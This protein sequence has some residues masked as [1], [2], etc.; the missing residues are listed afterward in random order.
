MA[1]EQHRVVIGVD[2]VGDA[3]VNRYLAA[4][5]KMGAVT[6]QQVSRIR[7]LTSSSDP[8]GG[9]LA[10]ILAVDAKGLRD[11]ELRATKAVAST[12]ALNREVR[13]LQQ[14]LASLQASMR[15]SV[16]FDPAALRQQLF[17]LLQMNNVM[18]SIQDT[19]SRTFAQSRLVSGSGPVPNYQ[20]SA[21]PGAYVPPARALTAGPQLDFERAQAEETRVVRASSRSRQRLVEAMNREA[22]ES[23]RRVG[24]SRSTVASNGVDDLLQI[25]AR[26]QAFADIFRVSGQAALPGRGPQPRT[27]DFGIP[28]PSRF[29]SRDRALELAQDQFIRGLRE[30]IEA[31]RQAA[32][33]SLQTAAASRRQYAFLTRL[34][35]LE[36]QR[37]ATLDLNAAGAVTARFDQGPTFDRALSDLA[38]V[39]AQI[40]AVSLPEFSRQQVN[41]EAA[42]VNRQVLESLAGQYQGRV[43]GSGLQ[44]VEDKSYLV[45]AELEALSRI[46]PTLN[47]AAS[48]LLYT[49]QAT[50]ALL[51]TLSPETR[52]VLTGGAVGAQDSLSPSRTWIRSNVGPD[53]PGMI[54]QDRAYQNLVDQSVAGERLQRLAEEEAR[55]RRELSA[56]SRQ[57]PQATVA[58]QLTQVRE[59]IA[60][61]QALTTVL[62]QRLAAEQNAAFGASYPGLGRGPRVLSSYGEPTAGPQGTKY[63]MI[64]GEAWASHQ[65]Y[66]MIGNL[67]WN[68]NDYESRGYHPGEIEMVEISSQFRR[69]GIATE[70]LTRALAAGYN[71]VHSAERT[72][73]GSAWAMA[74]SGGTAPPVVHPIESPDVW[75]GPLDY[76]NESQLRWARDPSRALVPHSQFYG[77][78]GFGADQ[79]PYLTQAMRATPGTAGPFANYDQLT[80]AI[81]RRVAAEQEA[82]R[83]AE[84]VAQADRR[85][86]EEVGR[87][88][89]TAGPGGSAGAGA[90]AGGSGGG[91]TPPPPPPPPPPGG[92]DFFD[93]GD[94][95]DRLRREFESQQAST[96]SRLESAKAAVASAEATQAQLRQRLQIPYGEKGGFKTEDDAI[97]AVA[98]NVRSLNASYE[99]LKKAA[100]AH[101]KAEQ[102][103]AG[104]TTQAAQATTRAAGGG[105]GGMG[106]GPPGTFWGDFGYGFHGR[107]DK[108]YA[109]QLGQTFKFSV[110]YG[111]AYK[112]LFGLTQT[113]AA[114][115]QEGI[116]F[117]QGMT[118]LAIATGRPK[119]EL[120]TIAADLGRSAVRAG[121][122]PSQGVEIGARSLGLYGVTDASRA[123]QDR[124]MLNSARVVN[125]LAVGAKKSP[126]ELQGDIAAIAQALG[127]GASGQFRIADLDAYMTR[128]FG[129]QQGST[130]ETVAQSASVGKA[131]G[132]T[133]EQ[134]FAIAADMISRTG[135]T[136]SAVAGFMAQI[137]S[138]GGEGS[139]VDVATK[140]GID[141][142]QQLSSIIQ[143]LALLYGN[144]APR[145]Q[146]QISAAFGRGKIQNA[147][148]A[149]LGDYNEVLGRS[150]EAAG[151][152][153]AGQADR[154]FNLRMDNIGGQIAQLSGVMKEFASL[155]GQ[156]GLLDILG[157]GIITFREFLEVVNGL[158]RLWNQMPDSIQRVLIGLAL[159]A[160]ASQSTAVRTAVG[161]AF[162]SLALRGGTPYAGA[163]FGQGGLMAAAGG[164]ASFGAAARS[165]GGALVRMVGPVGLAIGGLL[166]IGALKNSSDRMVAAQE[167]AVVALGGGPTRG[168]SSSEFSAY[169]SEL[170]SLAKQNKEAPGW[171]MTLVTLGRGNNTSDATAARLQTEADRIQGI[172]ERLSAT[173]SRTPADSSVFKS[174]GADDLATGLDSL[175]KSGQTASERLS[176]LRDVLLGTAQA[177]SAA[178]GVFSRKSF[179]QEAAASLVGSAQN[180]FT[181]MEL[182]LGDLDPRS[183]L[184]QLPGADAKRGVADAAMLQRGV[185]EALT[186]TDAQKRLQ[187]GLKDYGV[188]SEADLDPQTADSIAAI[189]G[190][191]VAE[192]VLKPYGANSKVIDSIQKQINAAIAADLLNMAKGVQQT[193]QGS[194]RLSAADATAL[195]GNVVSLS[196]GVMGR[197]ANID[198]RGQVGELRQ[199]IKLL[200]RIQGRTSEPIGAIS[201]AID[202]ARKAIAQAQFNE[203]ERLRRIAQ[204]NADS[205]KEIASI[206]RRFLTREIRAAVRGNDADLLAQILEQAGKGAITI[207]RN[208]I[209]DALDVVNAARRVA[210][211]LTDFGNEVNGVVQGQAAAFRQI[212]AATGNKKLTKRAKEL[213]KLAD[214]PKY[215]LPARGDADVYGSGSDSGNPLL[216]PKSKDAAS[217]KEKDSPAA[218]AAARAQ[219]YATRSESQIAAARA[220]V[221]SAKASLADAKKNTVEYWNAMGELFSAQ[222]ALTDAL[223]AYQKN[224]M[225]L[226][227]DMTNPL[228]MARIETRAA[229]IK[230]R[231]DIRS[232]KGADVIAQDRVDV[233]SAQANQEATAFSQRL[234]SVQTA[235]QLGRISHSKYMDYLQHEHD[236]LER[237]KHRTFQQQQQLDQIDGLMQD[238]A[239]QMQGQFNLGDIKLPTP[240]QVRRYI[241][242]T[243]GAQTAR[244]AASVGA[245]Q[246]TTLTMNV[247]GADTAKVIQ[248]VQS[249]VGKAG[250]TRTAAPRRK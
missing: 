151:G 165:A 139:L 32:V 218:I 91:G 192:R 174:L 57:L 120:D 25:V 19:G 141:P 22:D 56:D 73:A 244:L 181:G 183:A 242:Q 164:G 168:A 162:S 87:R 95:Y 148:V 209:N 33:A 195:A 42:R 201:E 76:N 47:K 30:R 99:N 92:G 172:A 85:L 62:R 184:N 121:F 161:G 136:P 39:Q 247:D 157:L 193:V 2:Y 5:Q 133:D 69:L 29:L 130:L 145:E 13:G 220:S 198:T 59:Q 118:D 147:A 55:I 8:N 97:R 64:A 204:R 123:E 142:N 190:E 48:A 124:V 107:Q 83:A 169:A 189:V 205:K 100:D 86:K 10:G 191:G 249:V 28:G 103:A 238:A 173:E 108:S 155:L 245:S 241:E 225:M 214:V 239:K 160:A 84:S 9:L 227:S 7:A 196:E 186:G 216:D 240:Y 89:L 51:R 44:G 127:L 68:A 210:G 215:T 60:L 53:V 67:R 17:Q 81:R 221:L 3:D 134:L 135:Q 49:G 208:V 226:A 102:Q 110:F 6:E 129:I 188:R 14:S 106:G 149:L 70:L 144:A 122:A 15:G 224:R 4:L 74:V 16:G 235:E 237:I 233:R 58:Q 234:Q 203:F 176:Q 105:R 159:L 250:R 171:L 45:G 150:S 178:E 1:T 228:K 104:A 12:A 94:E 43:G 232:G 137:F 158:L 24:L 18:K 36:Q 98:A 143:Q 71:V 54:N 41:A 223:Q 78:G 236:R 146:A 138:R 200:T 114:T 82:A 180:V 222:N 212:A 93:Q 126:V 35:A 219:A 211:A 27:S 79:Y 116:A 20:L 26:Q 185:T 109:E 37:G 166:A 128:K 65:S 167:A 177:A 63:Y 61:Q 179:A 199:R 152:A 206:G 11:Y 248:I 75:R 50:G 132:F 125:Q 34:D 52:E 77:L 112:L 119:E 90:G 243:S 46:E 153:A 156:S 96:F 117:Q 23:I 246:T 170:S 229:A 66:G 182:T 40:A 207:A 115:L 101:A 31:D 72:N 197:M 202:D 80:E 163:A 194:S 154:Q 175:E 231:Q 21:L 140:Q 111:T 217:E 113:L 38:R 88:A 213:E 131:A 187:Q 230:L